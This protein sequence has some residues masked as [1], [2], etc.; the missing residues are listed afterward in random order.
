M[1]AKNHNIRKK[2]ILAQLSYA[3]KPQTAR[4]IAEICP[5]SLTCVS[6]LLKRYVEQGLL[7]R[8]IENNKFIYW[9][10]PRG[11]A[12]LNYLLNIR[13]QIKLLI[14]EPIKFNAH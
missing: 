13:D 6:S 8:K 4:E 1:K 11:E 7:K 10:T 14:R 9:I 3:L 12:R 2:Q 5:V